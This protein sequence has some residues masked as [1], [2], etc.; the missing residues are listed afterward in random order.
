MANQPIL[1]NWPQKLHN[2]A[3]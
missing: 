2:S 3:K 1:C